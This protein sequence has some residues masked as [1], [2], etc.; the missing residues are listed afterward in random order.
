MRSERK[1]GRRGKYRRVWLTTAV[2]LLPFTLL[3]TWL[4]FTFGQAWLIDPLVARLWAIY[5]VWEQLPQEILWGILFLIGCINLLRLFL[6]VPKWTMTI[7]AP[8]LIMGRVSNWMALLASAGQPSFTGKKLLVEL[9]KLVVNHTAYHTQLTAD[10]V[11]TEMQA[12]KLPLPLSPTAVEL[13]QL[14]R[15][16][17]RTTR[18]PSE[19]VTTIQEITTQLEREA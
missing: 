11:E 2:V 5:L 15:T 8:P 4:L 13:L 18:S 7:P 6:T 19:T 17:T 12:G 14:N 3:G 1:K 10:E 16:F 9:R